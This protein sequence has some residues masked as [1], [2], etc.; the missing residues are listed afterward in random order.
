MFQQQVRDT[1][2]VDA[3][4]IF[5]V[6]TINE[7]NTVIFFLF[8]TTP[9]LIATIKLP[10]RDSTTIFGKRD[11]RIVGEGN[12]KIVYIPQAPNSSS[13]DKFIV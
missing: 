1:Q 9:W 4:Y 8:K 13:D 5:T 7:A 12:V 11:S 6:L 2:A 10:K 3:Q